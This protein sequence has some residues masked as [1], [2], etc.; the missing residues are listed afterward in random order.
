[1]LNAIPDTR[2]VHESAGG[3]LTPNDIVGGGHEDEYEA[4]DGI[5][6]HEAI[7]LGE[8]RKSS[9]YSGKSESTS[10]ADVPQ[11]DPTVDAGKKRNFNFF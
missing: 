7:N 8:R 11:R 10:S 4:E 6:P 5:V 3:F 1:M 9:L 2:M